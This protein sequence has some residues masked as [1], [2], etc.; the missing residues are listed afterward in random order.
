[1]DNYKESM[2][3]IELALHTRKAPPEVDKELDDKAQ[4]LLEISDKLTSLIKATKAEI[5]AS[6]EVN[7]ELLDDTS[8][9]LAE[10]QAELR[11]FWTGEIGERCTMSEL[12]LAK[13]G[14]KRLGEMKG[15]E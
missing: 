14:R 7:K 8:K 4:A 1:M 12:I 3:A 15:N 9:A 6:R 2:S 11:A 10:A 5:A 13:W